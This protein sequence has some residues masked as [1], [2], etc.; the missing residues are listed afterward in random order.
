M[1]KELY[2]CVGNG[3]CVLDVIVEHKV[4]GQLVGQLQ[5]ST[6][7]EVNQFLALAAQDSVHALSELT[8]G[9]HIHTL[10]CPDEAAFQRVWEA[11]D[12]EGF[13]VKNEEN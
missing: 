5:V 11:L 2:I 1:G 4:Y 10:R 12:A 8:D 7:Y 9:I 3:C 6:R 13:L